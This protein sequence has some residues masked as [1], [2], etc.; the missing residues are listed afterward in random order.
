MKKTYFIFLMLVACSVTAQINVTVNFPSQGSLDGRLLLMLSKN[1][2][3]EPRFQILDGHDTQM[4]FGLNLD[5]WASNTP[6][7]MNAD[8]TFGYP[9]QALK[10]IPAG[11]YSVQVLLHKYETFKRKDGKVVKLPMDRGEGQ[12]WNLAPGNIYSKPIKIVIKS[13]TVQ[14]IAVTLDQT[15]PPIEEPKDTKYIKHIKIQRIAVIMSSAK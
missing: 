2:K 5:N 14:N 15:I 10:D 6:K 4:V 13:K 11:E 1:D 12:Q 8:N 3:S 9:I 7:I